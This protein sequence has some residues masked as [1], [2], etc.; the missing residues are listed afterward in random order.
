MEDGGFKNYQC[1][2][3]LLGNV[4]QLSHGS[5]REGGENPCSE[6]FVDFCALKTFTMANFSLLKGRY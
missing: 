6:A 3:N 2:S 4:S 1:L 5:G